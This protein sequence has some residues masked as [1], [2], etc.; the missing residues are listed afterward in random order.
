MTDLQL[1]LVAAFLSWFSLMLASFLR[2]RSWTPSGRE[3]AFGNRETTPEVSPI[4]GR[5]DRA[6]RNMLESLPIFT[7]ALVAARLGGAAPETIVPGAHVFVWSRWVYLAVYLTGV[8]YLRTL[9]WL[10]SV[11]GMGMVAA[12]AL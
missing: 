2:S 5:A 10:V 8:P 12:A 9:V 11:V 4:A 3:F 1:L 6:A 7:A